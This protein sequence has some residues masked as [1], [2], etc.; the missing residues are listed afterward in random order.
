MDLQ[1]NSIHCLRN[2]MDDF[3]YEVEEIHGF[4][5]EHNQFNLLANSLTIRLALNDI[6]PG[7]ER[8]AR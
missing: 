6:S 7:N 8:I 4:Q 2:T 1:S 3:I 5:K